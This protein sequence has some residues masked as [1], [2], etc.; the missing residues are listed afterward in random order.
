[1]ANLHIV[2]NF[3][4]TLLAGVMQSSIREHVLFMI[5]APKQRDKH[6][7]ACK[8]CGLQAFLGLTVDDKFTC[9]YLSLPAAAAGERFFSY[10]CFLIAKDLLWPKNLRT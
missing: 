4:S 1:M 8:K 7:N 6:I 5:N 9:F 10:A 2:R 3:T